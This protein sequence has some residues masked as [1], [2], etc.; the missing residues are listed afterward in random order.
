MD[1]TLYIMALNTDFTMNYGYPRLTKS[2]QK[3]EIG[4]NI[5]SRIVNETFGWL[6]KRNHQEHDFG[7][8]CQ[9]E[10]VTQDGIV[11]GQ[12]LA[13]QIK[14]GS[15]FF[16]EKNR[17]GYVYRGEL[18]H[19]NYLSNYP[20]PVI[21]TICHPKSEE[22]YWV[23]FDAEETNLT[24]AGWKITIPFSNKLKTSKSALETQLTPL[25]DS[26]SELHEYWEINDLIVES[27]HIHYIIDKNQVHALDVASPRAF[28]DRLRVTKELA[29]HC[30]GKVV[31][32][33]YGYEQDP[34]ELFEI[35]EV[36]KYI[37]ALD[38]A[39]PELFFFAQAEAPAPT[40]KLFFYCQTEVS[41]PD[42]RS[43]PNASRKL[44]FDTNALA[45]FINNHWAG[46]N[47]M[48]QW[49]SMSIDENKKI[50]FSIMRYFGIKFPENDFGHNN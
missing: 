11:T 47:E 12:M 45:E 48:T 46:L 8:D 25:T 1:K 3:G 40:I 36:R 10:V 2:A 19:F 14:Y 38:P 7:I 17:W 5:V 37:T 44:E 16:Q 28:F 15:S 24:K 4:V 20:I 6:F 30:Q 39:L 13:M 35:E 49:L 31:I 27:S 32:T 29:Y 42:G 43:T 33:I 21:I 41:W 50:S 9:I 26:L 22:C 34:R 23:K 18:K